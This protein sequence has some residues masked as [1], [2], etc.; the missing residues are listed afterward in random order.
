MRTSVIVA[1]ART[2]IGKFGGAL[3]SLSATDLGG[4]AIKAAVNRAGISPDQVQYLIMGQVLQAGAGQGPARQAGIKG[5]L[6]L[7]IPSILVNKVCL[8]G[9]N[10]IALADQLIRL[11]ECDVIVAGGMES[12][13]NSPHLLV[14]SRTGNKLGDGV[15]KDSMLFD[16][17]FCSIDQLGMGDAT[18]NIPG[19]KGIGEKKAEKLIHQAKKLL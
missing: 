11:G 19:V 10:A 1:G 13:T 6:P 9:L 16:A 17:L 8:S 15:L 3:S 14:N 2:P 18:D 7:N 12:M 4:V 5:G